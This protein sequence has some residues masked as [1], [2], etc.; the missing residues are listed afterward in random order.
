M[1]TPGTFNESKKLI[2]AKVL[3]HFDPTK[4]LVMACDASPYGI[5]AVL[6]HQFDDE[7]EV[8]IGYAS[9]SLTPAEKNYS[10]LKD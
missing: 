3:T 7:T 4:K 8:P 5:G 6:S 1:E 9:R 2:A 10:Q